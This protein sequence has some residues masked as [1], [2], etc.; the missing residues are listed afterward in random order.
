[1]SELVIFPR[2]RLLKVAS[3]QPTIGLPGANSGHH[4]PNNGF[5]AESGRICREPAATFRRHCRTSADACRLSE[6]VLSSRLAKSVLKR[7]RTRIE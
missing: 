4:K 7:E 2:F 3:A 1:M 5:V 6:S